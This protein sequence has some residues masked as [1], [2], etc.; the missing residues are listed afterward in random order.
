MFHQKSCRRPLAVQPTAGGG[1][2][3][4]SHK[5]RTALGVGQFLVATEGQ[6]RK[7]KQP[8]LGHL[9]L[10]LT[11]ALRPRLARNDGRSREASPPA[12]D[13]RPR[14]PGSREIPG[15][16]LGSGSSPRIRPHAAGR[17][18]ETSRHNQASMCRSR[19]RPIHERGTSLPR[20][21]DGAD[22]TVPMFMPEGRIP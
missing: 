15:Y 14:G 20:T 11:P 19:G 21:N 12:T 13:P 4:R 6:L 16:L 3:S 18:A 17:T 10:H 2:V 22:Q 9:D 8:A 1:S 7:D 5:R